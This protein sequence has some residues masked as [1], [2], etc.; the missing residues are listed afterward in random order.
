MSS[1]AFFIATLYWLH[2]QDNSISWQS[3]ND[4]PERTTAMY[5]YSATTILTRQL[6]F[7]TVL[8][9]LVVRQAGVVGEVWYLHFAD[10]EGMSTASRFH[11]A[12]L[13]RVQPHGISVPQHLQLRGQC[14]VY[15]AV[16]TQ[17]SLWT[18][19]LSFLLTQNTLIH[20]R[21]TLNRVDLMGPQQRFANFP[22]C[23]PKVA[24]GMWPSNLPWKTAVSV[25]FTIN[26]LILVLLF[27]TA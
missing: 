24:N 23:D 7:L 22:V 19:V 3:C 9:D 4:N 27:N 2:L 20:N 1:A 25:M 5:K 12:P 15:N 6:E 21:F 10:D 13:C 14:L 17:Y 8:A 26:E 11:D 16:M 18:T